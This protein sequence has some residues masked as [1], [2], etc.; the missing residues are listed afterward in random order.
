MAAGTCSLRDAR[1]SDSMAQSQGVQ[2]SCQSMA[3]RLFSEIFA[4]MA[5]KIIFGKLRDS[6]AIHPYPCDASFMATASQIRSRES[7]A[8]LYQKDIMSDAKKVEPGQYIGRGSADAKAEAWQVLIAP[9]GAFHQYFR[10]PELSEYQKGIAAL[11]LEL[12]S[13]D[14]E[15]IAGVLAAL[16]IG[17]ASN[18]KKY[19]ED[20]F[21]QYPGAAASD[22]KAK[23]FAMLGIRKS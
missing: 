7:A 9:E 18:S 23:A 22:S 4:R 5:R 12:G 21:S 8:A 16:G 15:A 2:I 14:A 20:N 17:Q 1:K 10:N 6:L 13:D 3:S 19:L 11:V